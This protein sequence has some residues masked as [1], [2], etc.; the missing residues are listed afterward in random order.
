VAYKFINGLFAASALLLLFRFHASGAI[1][2]FLIISGIMIANYLRQQDW[3]KWIYLFPILLVLGG[4]FL[5]QYESLFAVGD[6]TLARQ[7]S[8]IFFIESSWLS[9]LKEPLVGWG[10]GHWHIGVYEYDY[11][12]SYKVAY[13]YKQ[14]YSHNLYSRLLVELGLVGFLLFF[15]PFIYTLVRSKFSALNPFEKAC[16]L[17]IIVYLVT[18]TFNAIPSFHTYHFSAMELFTFFSVGY[19]NR[20]LISNGIGNISPWFKYVFAILA[21]LGTLWFGYHAKQH[22]TY[23]QAIKAEKA[24]DIKTAID[25]MEGVYSPTWKTTHDFTISIN[26]KLAQFYLKEGDKV[27]AEENF[28]KVIELNPSNPVDLYAYAN[29]LKTEKRYEEAKKFALN[30]HEKHTVNLNFINLLAELAIEQQEVE[31]AKEYMEEI[32]KIAK[33]HATDGMDVRYLRSLQK[34]LNS[35]TTQ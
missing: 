3:F 19:L 15:I 4:G 34:K 14:F 9:F 8:R 1:L 32:K 13:G 28:K 30:A 7:T 27:K 23:Y 25:I 24:G 6:F 10:L 31:V 18:I 16:Y 35:N 22:N 5:Y 12:P 26:R 11:S 17:N 21:I 33:D 29:F 2:A 20:N